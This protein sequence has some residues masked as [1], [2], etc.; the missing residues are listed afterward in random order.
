MALESLETL[1][2]VLLGLSTLAE[3]AEVVAD[4]TLRHRL[5]GVIVALQATVLSARDQILRREAQ[6]E[7]LQAESRQTAAAPDSMRRD[8]PRTK[9]GCYQFDGVEG[10]FCTD[11]YDRLGRR[12]R[13]S[14]TQGGFTCPNC[15]TVFPA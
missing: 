4:E 7:K 10:L 1:D 8:K 5:T 3:T 9:W 15:M 13:T 6:F 11:C 14:P 12:I 2:A